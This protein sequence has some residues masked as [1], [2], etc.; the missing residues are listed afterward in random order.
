MHSFAAFQTR[1]PFDPISQKCG[2][3]IH[4]KGQTEAQR[5]ECVGKDLTE[6]ISGAV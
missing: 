2:Q 5:Y 3:N 6:V 1:W 4:R